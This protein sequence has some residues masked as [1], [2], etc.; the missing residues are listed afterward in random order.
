MP[1]FDIVDV[2]WGCLFGIF[3]VRMESRILIGVVI[4]VYGGLRQRQ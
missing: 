2:D 3:H 1:V 4:E